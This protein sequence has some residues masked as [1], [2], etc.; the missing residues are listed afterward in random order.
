LAALPAG[1]IIHN[2]LS[3]ADMRNKETAQRVASTSHNMTNEK[4]L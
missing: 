3:L 4:L 2:P 1:G